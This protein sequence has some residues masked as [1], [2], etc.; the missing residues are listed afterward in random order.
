M[1]GG[2]G[3]QIFQLSAAL[4]LAKRLGLEKILIDISGLNKYEI[5]HKNEL[6]YFF[7]FKNIEVQYIRNKILDFRIPKIFPLKF[8]FY[9]FINDKNFQW[10]MKYPN[11]QLII[12]DGYFQDCLLQ[13][14]FNSE[15]KILKEIFIPSKY[16]ENEEYCVIHIRGG[17]F[18]KLGWNIVSPK[19]YYIKA[20]D[21]MKSEYQ[22]DK[23]HIVT[24]DTN[25]AKTILDELN[26]DYKFI[27][28]N[29]YDDFYLI[30]RYQ[31]R[32]LSSSTF[33]LWASALANNENSVVISPEY[34]TP[35]NLRKIFLPNE[36][37]ILF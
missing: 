36:R 18:V 8:P 13:E 31:Y 15:I 26:I 12:L 34:W 22:R 30:G 1:V 23:F 21:I 2:L 11:K 37:R 5:K 4:L 32:I 24:D 20:I 35:N 16:D 19:E 29:I 6:V 17:D 28:N 25:Y 27:G 7:D 33:A 3:N 10:G 9:P 14:D